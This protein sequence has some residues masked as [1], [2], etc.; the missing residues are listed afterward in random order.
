L[1]NHAGSVKIMIT[2]SHIEGN[3]IDVVIEMIDGKWH[4]YTDKNN[5]GRKDKA[6]MLA[7]YKKA[8][9]ANSSLSGQQK[10]ALM[11]RNVTDL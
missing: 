4:S 1:A 3:D 7:A 5:K 11:N 9:A 8:I 6:L 10:A 2:I